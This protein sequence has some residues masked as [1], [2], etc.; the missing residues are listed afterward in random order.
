MSEPK[1]E[2]LEL[3]LA[4]GIIF[5][6]DQVLLVKSTSQGH[7]FLPGGKVDPGESVVTALIREFQEELAWKIQPLQFIGCYEH[8]WRHKKK[9][10][11]LID[12]MEINFL[13][14]CQRVDEKISLETPPSMEE[15]ISFH[16]VPL[17][18]LDQAHLL[19]SEFKQILP[20][21]QGKLA[22]EKIQTF[23]GTGLKPE[24]S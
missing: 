3:K 16:W 11:N 6:Q 8:S 19:P 17:H 24:I 9:S 12:V 22:Q 15:K 4:R 5:H 7:Y 23:W 20:R 1:K 14:A 13:W 18:Q 21:L 2:Y 10:G